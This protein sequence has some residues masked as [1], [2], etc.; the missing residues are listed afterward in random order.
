MKVSQELLL[1]IL[2]DSVQA[3]KTTILSVAKNCRPWKD[4]TDHKALSLVVPTKHDGGGPD[5]MLLKSRVLINYRQFL[6]N[7]ITVTTIPTSLVMCFSKRLTV[8]ILLTAVLFF[9]GVF[10]MRVYTDPLIIKGHIVT[11]PQKFRALYG[12]CGVTFYL[13][14]AVWPSLCILLV[15]GFFATLHAALR[16]RPAAAIT[17]ASPSGSGY[18]PTQTS[19]HS[20][21]S[22]ATASSGGG[23]TFVRPLSNDTS[24]DEAHLEQGKVDDM[25]GGGDEQGEM[26]GQAVRRGGKKAE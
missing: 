16:V 20:D 3:S 21:N 10:T 14:G 7:Y 13:C 15:S 4:F 25:M 24:P 6:Y 11:K 8:S 17:C 22:R 9:L 19:V 5:L 18:Q 12:V 23:S 2:L 1:E 26:I